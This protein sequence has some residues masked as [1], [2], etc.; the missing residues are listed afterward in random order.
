MMYLHVWKKG[1]ILSVIFLLVG[2]NGIV[3]GVGTETVKNDVAFHPDSGSLQGS[4]ETWWPMIHHDLNH[5]GFSPSI[6]PNNNSLLWVSSTGYWIESSPTVVDGKVFI[7]SEDH[8]VYC[9]DAFT[10][11]GIWTYTTN[12]MVVCSPTFS[13]GKIYVGSMDHHVYCLN[14]DTGALIWSYNTGWVIAQS[15][16]AVYH[17]KVYIG[18]QDDKVYCLDAENGSKLW[19]FT[20]GYFVS[21]SPAVVDDRVY[22][23]S[24]DGTLYCLDANTGALIWQYA[25]VYTIWTSSPTVS[26][27]RVYIGALDFELHCFNALTGAHL[28]NFSTGDFV[29]GTAA[30]VD[31]KVYIGSWDNNVYCLNA[32]TGEV[33]WWY[34]TDG[35]VHS[36][37]AVADGKVYVGSSGTTMYCLDA[38]TG[39]DIWEY[40]IGNQILSSPAI[41]KGKVYVGASDNKVYC[42]GANENHPPVAD[43]IWTPAVPFTDQPVLLDASISYDPDGSIVLYEWDWNNDGVFDESSIYATTTHVWAYPGNY[44]VT[45][46]VTDASMDVDSMTKTIKIIRENQPPETP[47]IQGK[48]IGKIGNAYLYTFVTTDPNEDDVTYVVDWGDG[49]PESTLGP[50]PS[51]REATAT[52]AWAAKG[53]Y[54]IKAKAI[55]ILGNESDWGVLSVVMPCPSPL[56]FLQYLVKLLGRF[57]GAFPLLRHLLMH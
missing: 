7:G 13:D 12:D 30:V 44:L 27:G 32:T 56:P 28:W 57:P 25:I 8:K 53:R 42:F 36:S 47:T 23:G 20:T 38:E 17:G 39:E 5:T 40:G 11:A 34:P 55:D 15:S 9:F 46:R 1:L 43:F 45:L 41:A 33:L 52:H 31:G 18:S 48:S 49:T 21:S 35:P 51:G 29:T 10:G 4:E 24:M 54:V 16:P 6:A 3:I 37:P 2:T 14:A 19:E 26:N 22:I 50:V